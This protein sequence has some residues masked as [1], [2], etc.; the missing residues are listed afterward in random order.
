MCLS[1]SLCCE[2]MVQTD[3]HYHAYLPRWV[4]GGAQSTGLCIASYNT[5]SKRNY[6]N[7]CS[8]PRTDTS[9]PP[10]AHTDWLHIGM[11]CL[12]AYTHNSHNT[13]SLPHAPE[14]QLTHYCMNMHVCV[15][16]YVCIE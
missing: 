2:P 4:P 5:H 10:F 11:T 9:P 7:P 1:W 12:S 14:H 13:R 3:R 6:I 8:Q 15:F 16:K